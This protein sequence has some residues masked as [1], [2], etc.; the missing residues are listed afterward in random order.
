MVYILCL[1]RLFRVSKILTS[2]VILYFRLL[3]TYTQSNVRC[4]CAAVSLSQ[5][6]AE[7]DMLER[8]LK[9]QGR[10]AQRG[11]DFVHQ[12]QEI[13]EEDNKRVEDMED[14]TSK[15]TQEMLEWE[16]REKFL[17]MLSLQAPSHLSSWSR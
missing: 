10:E 7:V 8:E 5:L 12:L 3:H 13:V 15:I 2:P 17:Q 1:E 14:N 9:K 16:A 6:L 4:T 11:G